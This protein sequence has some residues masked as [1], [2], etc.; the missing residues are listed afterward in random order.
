MTKTGKLS[1][2]VYLL[3]CL[4]LVFTGCTDIAAT[5][6]PEAGEVSEIKSSELPESSSEVSEEP[7][8]APTLSPAPTPT[9][10]PEE[11]LSILEGEIISAS[12]SALTISDEN[13]AHTIVLLSDETEH[14]GESYGNGSLATVSY[15]DSAKSGQN[16][17]AVKVEV[18]L[19][20]HGI[21]ARELLENMS[22]EEKVGQMFFVRC[23]DKAAEQVSRYQFG[24]YILFG[25]DFEGLTKAQVR[26]NIT[27][28]QNN[29]K[30]PMLIGVDE[31]GGTV[32]RISGN[33]NLCGEPFWS[34]RRLYNSGGMVSVMYA[35][36]NK[37][38]IMEELGV[39]VNFAPVCDISLNPADFM[40]DRSLGRT[41]ATT[42]DYI[43]QIVKFY[44]DEKTGCILKHF[45]GYGNNQ[46]TH[47]GIAVD[48]RPYETFEQE[49]LLPFVSGIKAGADCVLISHNIVTCVD[50]ERP[51]S[52]SAGWH[53]ILRDELGFT[54]CVITDDL[55]MGA[56]RDYC[57]TG[58]AAV[59][60]V[61]AGNDLLCCTD[62][63]V[64]IPAVLDAIKQGKLTEERIDLSVMRILTWKSKLGLLGE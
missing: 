59:Q 42:A 58:S 53:D 46:D 47:T 15:V 37:L 63:E 22:L 41:P 23:P 55:S 61:L 30:I 64:Q 29:S 52:L 60:A 35:E 17:R 9:I 11:A 13:G 12:K 10:V 44:E 18:R 27:G 26:N 54:G 38:K 40:Y 31:E 2:A 48:R 39:N 21:N 34:P 49:D 16:I 50:E 4:S 56:I 8:P 25:R 7:K 19:G 28:Y 6:V 62:Y 43:R 45:P 36:G 32:V 5:G 57:D 14:T 1:L 20:E 33:P 3:I 51:A 24:G